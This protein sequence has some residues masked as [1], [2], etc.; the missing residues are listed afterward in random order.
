M[1]EGWGGY[2]GPFGKEGNDSAERVFLRPV[3]LSKDSPVVLWGAMVFE[4]KTRSP[5]NTSTSQIV[6]GPDDL[7]QSVTILGLASRQ[8]KVNQPVSDTLWALRTS[9]KR[10]P[11]V[12]VNRSSR[13]PTQWVWRLTLD[14]K[15]G[16]RLDAWLDPETVST[17][18][19]MGEP[20]LSLE[21]FEWEG[22][23]L[24]K[25]SIRNNG[26]S[27]FRIRDLVVATR[28]RDIQRY[29]VWK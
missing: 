18:S 20:L 2:F 25:L 27:R 21:G 9:R 15:A 5:E 13:T 7:K 26:Q 8:T 24:R 22:E 23:S 17:E 6:I 12:V 4:V 11:A 1:Q 29:L 10:D 3:P 16:N 19:S 14:P 28:F